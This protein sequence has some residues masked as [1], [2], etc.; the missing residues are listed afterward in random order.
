MSMR[1]WRTRHCPSSTKIP[2]GNW[3]THK[4]HRCF[5]SNS[6]PLWQS[7]G[8]Q[9]WSP[10]KSGWNQWLRK[11]SETQSTGARLSRPP[12]HQLKVGASICQPKSQKQQ[13]PYLLTFHFV[14]WTLMSFIVYF[15]KDIL[16]SRRRM[17]YF[18]QVNVTWRCCI[19]VGLCRQ[20]ETFQ[21]VILYL[22]V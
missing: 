17:V 18:P 9:W 1:D 21:H 16:S 6:G 8:P 7:T 4:L 20:R 3:K 14:L 22:L 11:T 5:H 12:R 19:V 2:D 15:S 13:R 10:H